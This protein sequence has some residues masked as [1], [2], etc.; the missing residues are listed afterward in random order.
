M[1]NFMRELCNIHR[2]KTTKNAMKVVSSNW[3]KVYENVKCK[4]VQNN[5]SLQQEEK[6]K[7]TNSYSI[8]LMPGTDIQEGDVIE[9]NGINYRASR[10]YILRSHIKVNCTEEGAL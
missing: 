3:D 8:Y 9:V 4:F 5:S 10:P 2:H 1:K 6:A 7:L